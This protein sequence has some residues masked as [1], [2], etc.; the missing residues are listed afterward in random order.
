MKISN[1]CIFWFLNILVGLS[2][3][4]VGT[5]FNLIVTV[6]PT[7]DVFPTPATETFCSGGTTGIS[8]STTVPGTTCSF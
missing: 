1:W 4:T 6:R 5:P 3:M 8:L 2:A 7:P